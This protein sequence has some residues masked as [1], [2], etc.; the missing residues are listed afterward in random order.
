MQFSCKK[1]AKDK[2]AAPVQEA[3]VGGMGRVGR[4]VQFSCKKAAKE[5]AAAPVQEAGRGG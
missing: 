1:A 4:N 2:V 5:T 3:R